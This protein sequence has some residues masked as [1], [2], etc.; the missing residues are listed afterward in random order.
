MSIGAN[1]AAGIWI[2]GIVGYFILLF[3]IGVLFGHVATAVS[4]FGSLAVF[5]IYIGL[6]AVI[7][8]EDPFKWT[9]AKINDWIERRKE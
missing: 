9:G 5:M 3:I 2:L 8:D 6:I 7:Y 1:R 4:F